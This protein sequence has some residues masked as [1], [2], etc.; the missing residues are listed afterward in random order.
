MKACGRCGND[1]DLSAFARNASSP[2]GRSSICKTC[3]R[4]DVD[5]VKHRERARVY[6]TKHPERA[7]AAWDRSTKKHPKKLA[8]RKAVTYAVKT[9]KLVKQPCEGCGNAL[10][11]A[12]HEDYEKKLDVRWLCSECHG[13]EHR[14]HGSDGRASE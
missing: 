14:T 10:A 3:R 6:R 11:Q 13:K 5:P 9:G 7:K 1:L 8:A 2:D 4:D 12:H